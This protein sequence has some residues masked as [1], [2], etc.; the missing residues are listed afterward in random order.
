[1]HGCRVIGCDDTEATNMC[2]DHAQRARNG[3]VFELENGT[4]SDKYDR[5]RS[6]ANSMTLVDED[7]REHTGS[8]TSSQLHMF[9]AALNGAKFKKP[10]TEVLEGDALKKNFS[11]LPFYLSNNPPDRGRIIFAL[12][13]YLIMRPAH[14][15]CYRCVIG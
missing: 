3:E 15:L 5:K 12:P 14:Y 6:R 1:M 13:S 9:R 7:G 2:K 4:S 8:F 11:V 10:K